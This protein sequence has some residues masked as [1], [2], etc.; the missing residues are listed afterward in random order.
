MVPKLSGCGSHD[1]GVGQKQTVGLDHGYL[2]TG[3]ADDEQPSLSR[4]RA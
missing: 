2:A 1:G 4:E 3:E